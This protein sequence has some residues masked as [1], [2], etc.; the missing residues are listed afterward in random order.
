M[1]LIFLCAIFI[2][3]C[4]QHVVIIKLIRYNILYIFINK[5]NETKCSLD[6]VSFLDLSPYGLFVLVG[7]VMRN[8]AV[9]SWVHGQPHFVT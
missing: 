1:I 5:I 9:F 3:Y 6:Y 2:D 7:N 4:S 8:T